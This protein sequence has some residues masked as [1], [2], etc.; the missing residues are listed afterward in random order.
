MVCSPSRPPHSALAVNRRTTRSIN[1]PAAFAAK[2][3]PVVSGGRHWWCVEGVFF[4]LLSHSRRYAIRRVRR[5]ASLVVCR[6]VALLCRARE[7]GCE[8]VGLSLSRRG[9]A[10]AFPND[11][12][13]DTSPA[14]PRLL[15]L[16]A[17]K[18]P[19]FVPTRSLPQKARRGGVWGRYRVNKRLNNSAIS[20]VIRNS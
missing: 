12:E 7:S 10:F 11:R 17:M 16:R 9:R 20:P 14:A 5:L 1:R 8:A 3:P 4:V 2:R 19:V 6:R 13:K 15:G 18:V